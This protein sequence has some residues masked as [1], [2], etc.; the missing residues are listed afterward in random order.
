MN[1]RTPL[2]LAFS[3]LFTL[4]A[5]S[6]S[7]GSSKL[8]IVH[9]DQSILGESEKELGV[10]IGVSKSD[11]ELKEKINE[12]LKEISPDTR[13]VWMSEAVERSTD[14][15]PTTV[16]GQNE[17]NDPSRPYLTVGLECD[18]AP[19]N[20]T[21]TAPTAYTY[22]INGM[23]GQYAAGYD[24]TMAKALAEALNY[25]LRILK[26]DWEALIPAL[27]SGTVNAVIAGMTDTEERRLSIDFT[28]EYYRSEL[29]LIVKADSKYADA[30]SLNAFSGAKIV[31]QVSTITDDVIEDWV[32]EYGVTHLNPLE[33]FSTCAIAVQSGSAD[34][35]TAELP[36]A[37]SIVNGANR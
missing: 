19:F 14:E 20:W 33:T 21:E 2:L 3:A 9:F 37:N 18:Y 23:Q 6:C 15:N 17:D 32:K 13:N 5:A 10:S 26:M 12:A 31:S 34:A 30:D 36:V 1:L 24:V 25:N 22:P 7:G 28:D 8:K 29:V 27:Q 11:G 4:G 35:M 16:S